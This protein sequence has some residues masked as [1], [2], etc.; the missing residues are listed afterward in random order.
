M[1]EKIQYSEIIA[2]GF[3]EDPSHDSIYFDQFGYDYV[4]ITKKL[5]KKIYLDWEKSTQLCKLV[6]LKKVKTGDIAKIYQI[7]NLKELK[8]IIDFFKN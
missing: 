7:K 8:E 3:T 1:Q 4:I 5:S 6:R 2:L